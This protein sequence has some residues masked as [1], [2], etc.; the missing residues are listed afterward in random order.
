VL[1]AISKY[2][3]AET[4]RWIEESGWTFPV[5]CDGAEV[6]ELYGLKNP[7]VRRPEHEG[8]PHPATIVI[9]KEGTVR[10]VNVWEDYRQRTAPET[11]LEELEKLR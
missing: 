2:D 1:L 4:K 3:A 8:I 6:I 9:D 11:I 7:A 10:F 5:L